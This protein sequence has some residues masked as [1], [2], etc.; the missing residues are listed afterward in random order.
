MALTWHELEIAMILLKQALLPEPG[1]TFEERLR[2]LRTTLQSAI[3]LEHATIPPYLYALYSIKPGCNAEV[4]G[5]IR[6][7]LVQEMLHMALDCNVLNAIGGHPKLDDPA[8]L[9]T[10]PGTLPGGV[11]HSLVVPLA[12]LS[13]QLVHDVFMV[14]EEPEHAQHYPHQQ[15]LATAAPESITIG[16]FY[17][18]IKD[19]IS[20]LS[21]LGNIFTGALALQLQTGFPELQTMAVTDQKTALAALD[22]IVAQGEGSAISPLDPE[23]EL[24]HYYKYE[25]IYYGRKLIANP[26]PR[27]GALP[28]AF[29][30]HVIAFDP[31][32]VWPVITNP[33]AGDFDDKPRLRS[34]N[35]SFN[36]GYTRMLQ[37]LEQVFNGQP[38][39]LAPALLGMQ[40]LRQQAMVLMSSEIV[41]G[42]TAGPTFS[43]TPIMA[44][45]TA[46][47]E[48]A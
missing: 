25:E 34:L 24:A 14:I 4:T 38:D 12:P 20:A 44:G 5:I 16:Q 30:G 17:Q 39:R 15:S 22:L 33:T 29:V 35:D 37:D 48:Y 19:E 43:Y 40:A 13:K 31:A 41:P 23:H 46:S 11:E 9:P 28:W 8:F 1:A 21:K 7:V 26:A 47:R 2:K 36:A 45:A 18:H 10:Y 3:E 32:G 6:S 27:P 42:M